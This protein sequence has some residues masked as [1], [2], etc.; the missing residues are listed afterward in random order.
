MDNAT[1]LSLIGWLVD[2]GLRGRH[3]SELLS[4]LCERL[5]GLGMPLTR[6]MVAFDILHPTLDAQGFRWQRSGGI[7]REEYHRTDRAGDSE[8]W[9]LSPFAH[10]V[11]QNILSLRLRLDRNHVSG[12]FPLLDRLR[13]EGATDY[14]AFIQPIGGVLRIGTAEGVAFSWTADRPGGFSDEEVALLEGIAP[15][16][17]FTTQALSIGT[18]GRI[19]L[20]TYLGVDAADR[21]LQGNIMR[22]RAETIRAPI[23]YSDLSDFTR[24]ADTAPRV[25]LLALL[26]DYA[27]CLVDV[28]E[29]HGGH[30]LKFIGDGML[31]IFPPP[32][33]GDDQ[34]GACSRALDAALAAE[35]AVDALN[36]RRR[37]AGDVVTDFYLALHAG[38]LLYGNFGSRTRLDFTVLGP[39]VNEAS[40]I[41]A[42]CG[43][44]EQRIVVSSAFAE[45]S[46]ERRRQL[47]GL[48]R[49]ALRGV[50]RPQELF[51]IDR[52]AATPASVA[53][54][55]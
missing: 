47:V 22:G 54:G 24:I 11:K 39:T 20:R 13:A 38:E 26:N 15:V 17:A 30:V 19:L 36:G 6:A 45:A 23:W 50:A 43:S 44:V 33:P 16:V 40:R 1:T 3:Q 2:G 9:K 4:E 7:T 32:L 5:V 25:S 18:T 53:F 31:A 34:T 41:A 12:V 55:R 42:L 46:G 49:Y 37:A 35:L 14:L 21:V 27:Q 48:G 8:E 29:E 52:E 28:I 10:M 51:T